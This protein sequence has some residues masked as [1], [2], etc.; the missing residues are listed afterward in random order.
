MEESLLKWLKTFSG[1]ESSDIGDF[2]DGSIL[3]CV[4]QDTIEGFDELGVSADL[5]GL[6]K[7]L[8]HAYDVSKT[9]QE[10]RNLPNSILSIR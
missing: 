10:G 5:V 6:L 4:A 8:E 7:S 3:L 1:D 2:C 9:P